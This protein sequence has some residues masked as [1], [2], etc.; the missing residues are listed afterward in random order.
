MKKAVALLLSV[1]MILGM[2]AVAEVAP[3][4]A[5]EPALIA[6]IENIAFEMT[7]GGSTLSRTLDG[8][9]AYLSIDTSDGLALVAQAFNGDDSLL[10]ALAK[11]VGNQLQIGVDG[12]DKTYVIDIPQVNED[13]AGLGEALRPVLPELLK[14]QMPM[15]DMVSL[16]K[17]DLTPYLGMFAVDN[18]DDTIGFTV[19]HEAVDLLLEQLL[20]LARD[21]AESVP[22]AKQ[23]LE[24]LDQL[25]AA[26]MSF[27]LNGTVTDDGETQTVSVSAYQVNGEQTAET[28]VVIVNLTS[29]Q[30]ALTLTVDI[31]LEGQTLTVASLD[32]STDVA[33]NAL[34]ATLEIGGMMQF[35]LALYREDDLQKAAMTLEAD[36]EG[37]AVSL[38]YNASMTELSFAVDN[39]AQIDIAATVDEQGD[40]YCAGT[41]AFTLTDTDSTVRVTADYEE[42][43]GSNQLGGYTLPVAVAPIETLQNTEEAEALQAALAPLFGY[44][45][46]V[47]DEAA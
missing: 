9:E 18:G 39:T 24:M 41:L 28:P 3:D 14:M 15:I 19:P 47:F 31:P 7:A 26:G 5:L 42:F 4:A 30:D 33:A 1:L 37:F 10:L 8:F 17:L 20:T 32:I 11:L 35:N 23:A 12:V 38:A 36:E 16:P 40:D 21:G 27:T 25:H 6:D 2:T 34:D 22:A 13:T 45:A 43:L 29:A 44:F 46:Q